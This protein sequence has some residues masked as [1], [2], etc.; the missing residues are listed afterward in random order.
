MGLAEITT[1]TPWTD[2]RPVFRGVLTRD[3]LAA[4]GAQGDAITA[5]ALDDYEY[6]IPM[7][8]LE[9][10]PIMVALDM[11]GEAMTPRDLGPIWI[12]YPRDDYPE[13]DTQETDHRM[14][15]QVRELVIE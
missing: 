1:Q 11:N 8:K 10:Y 9:Q 5:V 13:L 14:V 6:T 7:A 3:L 2:G 4:V 15:W 12:V